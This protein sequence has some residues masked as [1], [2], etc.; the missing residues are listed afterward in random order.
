MK[1]Y[2]L[3][4]LISFL[5]IFSSSV[6]AQNTSILPAIKDNSMFS[7]SGSESLGMGKLFAGQT[8]QGNNRRALIEFDLSAIPTD[9]I[10]TEVILELGTENSGDN[11]DGVIEIFGVT[12]E[13]GE[14]DSFGSGGG[15]SAVAPDATWTDAMFGTITWDTPGGDFDPTVLSSR[16]TTENFTTISFPSSGNFIEQVEAWIN[17][18]SSNHG[19]LIRGVEDLTCSAYRF[20][21]KDTGEAPT[22]TVTWAEDCEPYITN[23]LVEACEEYISPAGNLFTTSQTFTETLIASDGCDSIFN[24]DLVIHNGVQILID[25]SLCEGS[26]FTLDGIVFDQNNPSGTVVFQ[27]MNGCDSIYNV[28]LNF[29]PESMG[30]ENYIGCEGDGYTVVV[31]GTTY[32]ESNPNGVELLEGADMNGCDSTVVIDLVFGSLVQVTETY[33]GC[34]GDGF[35]IIVDGVIYDEINSTGVVA[36]T[37]VNGCDS[38]VNISLVFN[39]ASTSAESFST[40]DVSMP[41]SFTETLENAAFNGCDS[42]ITFTTVYLP[43]DSTFIFA[44]SCNPVDVGTFVGILSNTSGCDSVIITIVDLLPSDEVEILATTCD[45]NEVGTFVVNLANTSGCDSIVTIITSLMPSDEVEILATTCDPNEVG[46]VEVIL[47]NTSGC[48]SIVTTITSLMP[49]DEVEILATTCDPNEVGTVEVILVNTSGCDSVVTTIT[50]LM[51]SDEV[52][53][54]ATTCDPNEVGTVEVILVNTSGCDSIVTTITSLMPSDEVEILA[55]TCDPNEVGTV[56]VILIN[57]NGCDSVVTT[58]TSFE[59]LE[60]G[61]T[62]NDVEVTAVLADA[63]YQWVDCDNNNAPVAGATAQSFIPVESGN[64]A[65]MISQD[66]C[67]IM[68]E[69]NLIIVTSTEDAWFKNQLSVSPNPTRGDIRLSFGDLQNVNIR[70]LDLMGRV[71]LEKRGATGGSEDLRIDGSAGVYFVEVEVEGARAWMK[72]V[73][74]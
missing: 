32:S 41:P 49:S 71:L 14:G 40:C 73:V 44:G 16:F 33:T 29:L 25:N 48:D 53:I 24:I 17:D 57:T 8:C 66:G 30:T 5:L 42:I 27:D 54:L 61:V 36:L 47:V 64:Y 37:G 18:P 56:E 68:S 6:F 21:S 9:A 13:W 38:I 20:G 4:I 55:T 7:E 74:E 1:M 43:T 45:P 59:P 52:E 60:N 23:L 70:I 22:L 35:S 39:P 15:G 2:D 31:N 51:P 34:E 63:E 67:T 3:P 69:C 12:K 26:S 58:I 50:S 28:D 19:V 10:I 11:G 62:V 65:V 46:T 72:V